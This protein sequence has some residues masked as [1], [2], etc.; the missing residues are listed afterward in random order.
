VGEA[1]NDGLASECQPIHHNPSPL[2]VVLRQALAVFRAR[3]AAS[4]TG[5]QP[6]ETRY[7]TRDENTAALLAEAEDIVRLHWARSSNNSAHTLS[8]CTCDSC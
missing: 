1:E 4:Y 2:A 5:T 3:M 7:P 8:D 6:G